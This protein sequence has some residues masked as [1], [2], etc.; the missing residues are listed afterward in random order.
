MTYVKVTI[1]GETFYLLK[2]PNDGW[3]FTKREPLFRGKD[4]EE[5][6]VQVN[7]DE[8]ELSTNDTRL[9]EALV[10]FVTTKQTPSGDRMIGYYPACIRTLL[11][12]EALIHAMGFEIDF[13]R[14]DLYVILDDMFTHS[15]T[16]ERVKQ[17]EEALELIP[18]PTA[19]YA[20]R[21]DAVI[22]RIRGGYKLNTASIEEIVKTF[23][24]GEAESY[25]ENGCL[26][27]KILPP[28]NN[29]TFI[30]DSVEKEIARRIPAHLDYEV[31]LDYATWGEIKDN[32]TSWQDVYD[33][34]NSWEDV[35][36]YVAPKK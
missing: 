22:A 30:F 31:T 24:G 29:R 19:T 8:V 25:I 20:D 32:F 3:L 33:S 21:R 14:S 9:I 16:L 35:M 34:F 7:G 27:V 15:M 10:K 23:T 5:V 1:E 13:L 11:E 36:L 28:E 18:L 2:Q 4:A 26:Y 17:W 6:T 12:Y